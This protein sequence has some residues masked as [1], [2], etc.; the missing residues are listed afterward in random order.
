[1][2]ISYIFCNCC[3]TKLSTVCDLFVGFN[4]SVI[5]VLRNFLHP[6]TK[7]KLD[8]GDIHIQLHNQFNP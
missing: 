2:L 5:V 8:H 6:Y 1:M 4:I 7:R 3:V